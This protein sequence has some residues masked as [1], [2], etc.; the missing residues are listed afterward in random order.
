MSVTKQRHEKW[1]CVECY[2]SHHFGTA[3]I[4]NPDPRWDREA[5]AKSMSTGEWHDWSCVCHEY[6]ESWCEH[7]DS[8]S[9]GTRDFSKSSC[10]CCGTLTAGSRHRMSYYA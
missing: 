3:S 4:E 9:D 10:D 5:C 6:T 1:V 2:I 7:C 8:D